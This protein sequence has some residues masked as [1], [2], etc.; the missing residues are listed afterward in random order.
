MN[1]YEKISAVIE[2]DPT[3]IVP[4]R[5]Y[6]TVAADEMKNGILDVSGT[7][8][9][10]LPK[11]AATEHM[12]WLAERLMKEI[13]LLAV[14]HLDIARKMIELHRKVL[15]AAAPY[16]FES[17][18]FYTEF[19]REPKKKFYPPRRKVLRK[20]VRELQ[21][22]T[23][24]ELDVLS[25]SLPPGTGKTTLALFYLTWLA[26]RN[27]DEPIL[28]GSHSNAFIRGAYDE[29][30]RMMDPS[31]EYLW[32]DVFPNVSV[33]ST[34]AKECRIDIGGKRKRFE[35]LQ[36]TSI[37]SGNAGLYRAVQLLYCDD[38]I[39]GLE[40]A[41]SAER[42]EN[43]WNTYTTDLRQRKLGDHCKELHIAT[44]WS[45]HDV[46]GRL[47]EKYA[48]NERAEFIAF[49]A[50]DEN[51]ESNFNY[52]YGVGYSTETLREQ[53]DIMDDVSWK[54]L[55]MNEPIEREGLLFNADEMQRYFELP[56]DKPDAVW[57]VCDTKD[58]GKDY[59]CMPIAYQYG[60]RFYIED[61]VCD[62]GTPDLID[63]RLADKLVAHRVKISQFESNSAG[64]RTAQAVQ[65]KVKEKGGTTK[66]VTKFTSQNKMT[67]ILSESPFI[68]EHFLFKDDSVVKND[69]EYRT[70]LNM[71]FNF[72]LAGKNAHDDVPDSLAMLADFVQGMAGATVTAFKRPF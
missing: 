55:F 58:K 7:S 27:C 46:I 31:G 30:L 44:R 50:M 45:V 14:D 22:L 18:L 38:L 39:S 51:D 52:K 66:I 72:S 20:V 26:G 25:I 12:V 11:P 10:S 33:I 17:F 9:S 69:K 36:F 56:E 64:G 1:I 29:C 32:R 47:G 43:L 71:L 67:K 16:D 35:T 62:N 41:L 4:Y 49:P 57:S 65:A 21:R 34:N 3:D 13:P 40:V 23:D 19:E 48:D 5:D 70:F 8:I 24:D 63:I 2:K 28:T 54:A 6:Y 42:L 60:D 37:G 53:R 68:K 61:A 59:C 15:L